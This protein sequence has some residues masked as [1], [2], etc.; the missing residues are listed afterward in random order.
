MEKK[1]LITYIVT[2]LVLCGLVLGA[3]IALTQS[4]D[5]VFTVPPV[6]TNLEGELE[7]G[8]VSK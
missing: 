3:R 8:S 1:K 5:V 4:T 7:P 6:E 2:L